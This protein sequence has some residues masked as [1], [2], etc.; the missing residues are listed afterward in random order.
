MTIAQYYTQL[1]TIWS[2]IFLYQPVPSYICDSSNAQGKERLCKSALLL[3]HVEQVFPQC[4]G[5]MSSLGTPQI[6]STDRYWVYP[7][8]FSN[9]ALNQSPID[10]SPVAICSF[11]SYHQVGPSDS[12]AR[13]FYQSGTFI[14]RER[15]IRVNGRIDQSPQV[16]MIC[17]IKVY[18]SFE[19]LFFA[20]MDQILLAALLV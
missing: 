9:R 19:L 18:I 6:A 12:S 4:R 16:M 10:R 2:E 8:A 11:S 15:R 3:F 17:L 5:L 13:R 14:L 1:K 7:S 20:W